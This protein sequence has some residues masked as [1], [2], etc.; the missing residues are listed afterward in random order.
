MCVCLCER[1][2]GVCMCA[3]LFECKIICSRRA[4]SNETVMVSI[5]MLARHYNRDIES[6][7]GKELFQ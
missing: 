1:V 5:P 6:N 7:Y 3:C 4:C 2:F